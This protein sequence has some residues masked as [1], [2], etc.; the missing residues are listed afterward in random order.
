MKKAR[1]SHLTKTFYDPEGFILHQKQMD[2]ERARANAS[3]DRDRAGTPNTSQHAD[4]ADATY[5]PLVPEQWKK[6][7]TD[8]KDRSI[9]KMPRVLQSLFYLLRYE[10]DQICESGTNKLDLKKVKKLIGD[11]LFKDMANYHPFDANH[12]EF[13]EYQKLAFLKKQMESIE[14][15]K[16]EEYDIVMSKIY[17]WVNTAIELR[18][19]DVV[20]RRDAKEVL[21]KDREDAIAAD[22]ERTTKMEAELA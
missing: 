6:G 9:I 11:V 8:I 18:C 3:G 14:E 4:A 12:Q 2:R 7:V 22:G 19:E 15:E 10:R 20:S 13:K 1:F 17:K 16:V 5:H 21:K